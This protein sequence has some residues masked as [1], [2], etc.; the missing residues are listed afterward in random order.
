MSD[1]NF[2]KQIKAFFTLMLCNEGTT[3]VPLCSASILLMLTQQPQGQIIVI[4]VWTFRL[5]YGIKEPEAV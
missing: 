5:N 4:H 2:W 1:K 3:K